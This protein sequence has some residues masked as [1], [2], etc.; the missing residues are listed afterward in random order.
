MKLRSI[1]ESIE[2]VDH[3]GHRTALF[4]VAISTVAELLHKL[5]PGADNLEKG[6]NELLHSVH[7]LALGL[8][9]LYLVIR[10]CLTRNTAKEAALLLDEETPRFI[11]LFPSSHYPYESIALTDQ[12]V[13][14][15]T[16]P[17]TPEFEELATLNEQAFDGSSFELETEKLRSRNAEWILKNPA[18]F[19]LVCEPGKPGIFIGYTSVVPLNDP[20]SDVYLRGLIKDQDWPVSLLCSPGEPSGMLLIFAIGLQLKL[21]RSR[22]LGR[23]NLNRLLK[24]LEYHIQVIAKAHTG[25]PEGMSVWTQSEHK[26]IR[27]HL[28]NRGFRGAHPPKKSAEGFDML[29][30]QIV[31]PEPERA[32]LQNEVRIGQG[33]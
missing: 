6:S 31:A 27:R 19:M 23:P 10:A 12:D 1:I 11:T 30:L 22:S 29:R 9:L 15:V 20:G 3:A 4:L 7:W 17:E 16:D 18:V 26:S 14:F 13:K 2:S 21:R 28:M 32:I 5:V 8:A 33:V 24:A 25:K